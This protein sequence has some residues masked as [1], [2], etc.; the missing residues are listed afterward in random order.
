MWRKTDGSRPEL[1]RGEARGNESPGEATVRIS[2]G[3]PRPVSV[4]LLHATFVARTF[5]FVFP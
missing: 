5:V 1:G 2:R 4:L 3:V